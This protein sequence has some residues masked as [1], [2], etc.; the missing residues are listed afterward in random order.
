MKSNKLVIVILILIMIIVS[1]VVVANFKVAPYVTNIEINESKKFN[2]KVI[3]NVYIDNYFFKFNKETWCIVTNNKD[4]K[5]SKKDDRW[6]KANNG[7]CS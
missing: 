7:Y 4:D 6:T 5:V 3:V 2:D 1:L